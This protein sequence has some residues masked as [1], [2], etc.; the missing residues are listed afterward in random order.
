LEGKKL[1]LSFEA[2]DGNSGVI[3]KSLTLIFKAT[4]FVVETSTIT[5]P[6]PRAKINEV[7]SEGLIV[8]KFY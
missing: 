3:K 1:R 4:P 8:I 7:S 6:S 2:D 5:G